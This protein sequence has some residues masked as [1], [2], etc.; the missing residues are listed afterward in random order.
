MLVEYGFFLT[1]IFPYKD[2]IGPYTGKRESE[3]IRILTYFT[4]CKLKDVVKTPTAK[5][6]ENTLKSVLFL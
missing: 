2:K 5:T 6:Y 3:K 4:Q 1:R